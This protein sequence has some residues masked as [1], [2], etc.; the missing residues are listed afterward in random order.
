MKNLLAIVMSWLVLSCVAMAQLPNSG[1][2][3]VP[4]TAPAGPAG[5]TSVPATASGQFNINATTMLSWRKALANVRS[6]NGRG[7]IAIL[8]ASQSM[9]G[10]AGSAG[11]AE[12][13]GAFP[14]SWPAALSTLLNSTV[15][16]SYKSLFGDQNAA[17]G[18]GVA[19]GTYD[20][21]VTL[22]ANWS[23]NGANAFGGNMFK[24]TTG[25]ANNFSFTPPGSFDKIVYY[26]FT[27]TGN[28]TSTMNVDGGASLGTIDYGATNFIVQSVTFTVAAATH[29]INIVPN[30]NGN[31]QFIGIKTYLSTTNSI[32]IINGASYGAQS[33]FYNVNS[34]PWQPIPVL[35][36]VL[37][38]LVIYSM[39]DNDCSAVVPLATFSANLQTLITA[40]LAIG[41]I[42]LMSEAPQN[43]AAWTSG[44][45]VAYLGV[46]QSL[47]ASNNIPYLNLATRWISYAVTNPI[48][49][50]GDANH[51]GAQAYWDWAL[52]VNEVISNP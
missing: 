20:T 18:A 50:Y 27:A 8:G 2:P 41:S 19:Y 30:N 29:T 5:G 24:Y 3:M 1:S 25:A 7:T 10:G 45:C 32:D 23:A 36:K 6:G 16:T 51:P 52:A 43:V 17:V 13:N 38:D 49:P 40:Q 4:N 35:S 42:M 26:Y 44:S 28:G 48:F 39:S 34:N 14:L 15:S 46:L 12:L 47:A 9:G 33:N 21:R 11:T 22:G 37:P 31:F